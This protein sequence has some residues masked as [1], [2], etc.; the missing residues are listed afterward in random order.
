M[1]VRQRRNP[2]SASDKLDSNVSFDCALVL[3]VVGLPS[4][5]PTVALKR[6][7]EWDAK[8]SHVGLFHWAR[9]V[10]YKCDIYLRSFER[11]CGPSVAWLSGRARLARRGEEGADLLAPVKYA[12]DV[13]AERTNTWSS[14]SREPVGAMVDATWAP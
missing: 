9:G 12:S 10:K 3:I 6:E 13:L 1:G 8:L 2:F 11:L 14:S 4:T 7:V 5:V